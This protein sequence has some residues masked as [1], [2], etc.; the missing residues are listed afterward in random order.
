MLVLRR[1]RVFAFAG[2][3]GRKRIINDQATTLALEVCRREAR[4]GG[5]IR[6]MNVESCSAEQ[7]SETC[8]S[9]RLKR[10]TSGY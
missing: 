5:L 3:A 8:E 2:N 9:V 4:C 1:E 10:A 6:T 7:T